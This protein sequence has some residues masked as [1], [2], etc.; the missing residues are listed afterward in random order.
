MKIREGDTGRRRRKGRGR[1]ERKRETERKRE[2]RRK[3]EEKD[4]EKEEE[5][6]EEECLDGRVNEF[7]V[8]SRQLSK[9]S[10]YVCPLLLFGLKVMMV[11][12]S[13]YR[14]HL[15][16]LAT[17]VTSLLMFLMAASWSL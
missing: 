11:S 1:R 7:G 14:A 5:K 13:L 2:R 9:L 3:K 6:E 17:Q 4:E 10:H 15:R 12:L 8:D 16:L